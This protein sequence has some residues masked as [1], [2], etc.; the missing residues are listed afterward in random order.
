MVKQLNQETMLYLGIALGIFLTAVV[1]AFLTDS[2]K[3][4]TV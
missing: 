3:A 2:K 4:K 1:I